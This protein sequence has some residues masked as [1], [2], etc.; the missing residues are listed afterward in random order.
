LDWW[1]TSN[2]SKSAIFGVLSNATKK[3][4][5]CN[6]D[7]IERQDGN[8]KLPAPKAKRFLQYK[9]A[10]LLTMHHQMA[11]HS[12]AFEMNFVNPYNQ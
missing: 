6:R 9:E 8:D 1:Q 7:N 2:P 5:S 10:T 3:S 12:K 4:S 11:S